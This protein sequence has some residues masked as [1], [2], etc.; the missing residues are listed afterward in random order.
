M[1][2]PG[3]VSAVPGAYPLVGIL[4][5]ST[6]PREGYALRFERVLNGDDLDRLMLPGEQ[7]GGLLLARPE[8]HR[9][10]ACRG[11]GADAFYPERY[12]DLQPARAMCEACPVRAQ[13]AEAGVDDEHG[14]WGGVTPGER[15]RA[16]TGRPR[17][18]G[19]GA[20]LVHIAAQNTAKR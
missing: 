2:G 8:W 13:C 6:P 1:A 10:A 12:R 3:A 4:R 7:G 18:R 11:V 9:R 20:H 5:P 16:R 15:S 19:S 17:R 14:V